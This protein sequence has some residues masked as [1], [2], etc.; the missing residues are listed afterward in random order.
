LADGKVPIGLPSQLLR[1][2]PDIAQAENQ[3]DSAR[4]LI[5]SYKAEY[6]PDFTL[7][8]TAG[9]M[10]NKLNNLFKWASRYW[11][12][13]P[14]FNWTLIDF[15]KI[16]ANVRAQTSRQQQ[17]LLNYEKV[18]L[19]SFQEVENALV[20]YAQENEKNASLKEEVEADARARDLDKDLYRA[21]LKDFSVVLNA[22]IKLMESE[23]SYIQSL[24]TLM[25]DL[26]ALY[27]ALGGGWEV[28]VK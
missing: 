28:P 3:I 12:I 17:A 13:G 8:G 6:F 19:N 10:S 7:T 9:I 4:A 25:T 27:K 24:E 22:E 23:D 26:V 2:R 11:S 20:A 5:G 21:G 14:I 15:G 1:R 18:V 16:R